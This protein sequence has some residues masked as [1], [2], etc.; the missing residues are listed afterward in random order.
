MM[1]NLSLKN[2]DKPPAK[3]VDLGEGYTLLRL[4]DSVAHAVSTQEAEAILELWCKEQWPNRDGWSNHKMIICWARIHLPNSQKVC[5]VWGERRLRRKPKR[6][7]IV[8]VR[9]PS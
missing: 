5:S 4:C 2:K 8:R 7:M 1:P 9:T 3:S 6:T